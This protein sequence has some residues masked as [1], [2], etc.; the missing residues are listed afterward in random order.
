MP[1]LARPF[2]AFLFAAVVGFVAAGGTLHA[3]SPTVVMF[4]GDPLKDPIRLTDSDAAAFDNL[5]KPN[6]IA[7][8]DLS[9]RPYRS[10]AIFWASRSNP[11]GNG[12]P[13]EK[14]TPQMAWQH[15]RLYLPA[16][17]KPAVLVTTLLQKGM[18]PVPIPSN[19]QAFGFGGPVSEAALTILKQKGVVPR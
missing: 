10:V 8:T 5:L 2:A 6:T 14:L 12:T 16:A 13:V 1:G 7:P 11:A 9:K 18:Q 15:G 17:G 3:Q 19:D 4:Y